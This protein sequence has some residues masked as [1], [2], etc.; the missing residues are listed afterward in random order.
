MANPIP[1]ASPEMAEKLAVNRAGRLTADQRRT[2]LLA[3]GVALIMLLCP[4]TLLLQMGYVVLTGSFP[5][6][7]VAGIMFTIIGVLF[8]A[9]FLALILSNL[10]SFLP[11]AFGKHPVR[12]ARGP[13]EIHHSER[14]RPELPFSYIIG[15][16][17]FAPFVVPDDVPMLP[18][19]PYLVYYAAHSRIL[20]SLVALDAPDAKQW[21]PTFDPPKE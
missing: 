13:L 16:Y 4:V 9:L 7:T 1:P 8:I 15:D 10:Q 11:D 21:E 3:A 12:Y 2:V 19:A 14:N 18:G 6:L 5:V 17:S 20:L